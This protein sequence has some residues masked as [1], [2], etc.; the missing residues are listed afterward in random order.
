MSACAG[1]LTKATG[2]EVPDADSQ[3]RLLCSPEQSGEQETLF[4]SI[5]PARSG[6]IAPGRTRVHEHAET[7]K[8]LAPQRQQIAWTTRE[9]GAIKLRFGRRIARGLADAAVRTAPMGHSVLNG[10]PGT[11]G[12]GHWLATNSLQS[13]YRNTQLVRL[14]PRELPPW[15]A[16]L[17]GSR[18]RG[19]RHVK[20]FRVILSAHP[21]PFRPCASP[22]LLAAGTGRP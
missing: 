19:S 14:V 4:S 1:S 13:D 11:N 9:P 8:P 16:A 18:R 2:I 20:V 17:R 3:V 21:L 12:A 15:F 10:P 7:G 5:S 22:S 6:W